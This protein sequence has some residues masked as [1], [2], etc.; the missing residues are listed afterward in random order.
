MNDED[1]KSEVEAKLQV[2]SEVTR[3]EKPEP[4]LSVAVVQKVED[5]K[6]INDNLSLLASEMQVS[7]RS[8]NDQ[9]MQLAERM[10]TLVGD[11][12]GE[13]RDVLNAVKR[14]GELTAEL[15][16]RTQNQQ[17]V[18][19]PDRTL[20]DW[21]AGQVIEGLSYAALEGPVGAQPSADAMAELAYEWAVALVKRSKIAGS[22]T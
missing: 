2:E 14:L 22:Q 12:I 13:N 1:A 16:G 9:A 7:L 21:F 8:A 4:P 20:L 10:M 3:T 11:L 6:R 19:R 18:Q 17:A 5:L 15:S